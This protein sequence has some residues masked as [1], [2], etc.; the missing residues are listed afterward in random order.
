MGEGEALLL[1]LLLFNCRGAKAAA[2]EPSGLL[3]DWVAQKLRS[4]ESQS[5]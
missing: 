1:L 3:L 2:V 4:L 5:R